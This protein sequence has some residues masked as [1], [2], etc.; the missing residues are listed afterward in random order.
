MW[1]LSLNS[2][3]SFY[4]FSTIKDLK[5]VIWQYKKCQGTED[6][7]SNYAAP[8]KGILVVQIQGRRDN[9]ISTYSSMYN[10]Q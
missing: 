2:S 9:R 7:S 8:Q 1:I 10:A 3:S 5:H 6:Q 4:F